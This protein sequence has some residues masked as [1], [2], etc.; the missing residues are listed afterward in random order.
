[1]AGLRRR[2]SLSETEKFDILRH[3]R[4]GLGQM[5]ISLKMDRPKSIIRTF[6]KSYEKNGTVFPRRRKSTAPPPAT[7]VVD[8][9]IDRLEWNCRLNL[10]D[11]TLTLA[12]DDASRMNRT[13][14]WKLHHDHDYQFY[15]EIEVC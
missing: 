5:A 12:L 8:A 6:I 15:K 2:Q 1:M 10:R 11:H 9:A 7:S 4:N 3:H 13:L 14:L